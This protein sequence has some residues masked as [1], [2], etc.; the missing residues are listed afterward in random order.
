MA[1]VGRFSVV[2]I[3]VL[4]LM[5]AM[6]PA[7]ASAATASVDVDL[8]E[9]FVI[10]VPD[11]AET[12]DEAFETMAAAR[13]SPGCGTGEKKDKIIKRWSRKSSAGVKPALLRCGTQATSGLRHINAHTTVSRAGTKEVY[14]VSCASARSEPAKSS[15]HTRWSS[16][17]E[18]APTSSR[19][20]PPAAAALTQDARQYHE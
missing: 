6:I 5:S 19:H 17:S 14:P 13:V 1:K 3:A 7:G 12:Y 20:T 11:A 9:E 4:T 10:Y 15:G 16:R 8:D 2:M 18:R